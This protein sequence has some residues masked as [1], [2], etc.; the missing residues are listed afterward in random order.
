MMSLIQI[1]REK[2]LIDLRNKL[3]EKRLIV[4]DKGKK[5]NAKSE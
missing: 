4:F 5:G 1:K 2:S 3:I